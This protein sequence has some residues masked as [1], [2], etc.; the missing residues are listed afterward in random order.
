[1]KHEHQSDSNLDWN[2]YCGAELT[3]KAEGE[4]V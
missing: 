3:I 2:C 1:M 4:N